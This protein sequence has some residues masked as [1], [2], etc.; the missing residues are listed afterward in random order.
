MNDIFYVINY[1]IFLLDTRI[2]IGSFSFTFL[3]V[4]IGMAFLSIAIWAVSK[5]FDI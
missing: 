5:L 1:V 3:S 2:T 4:F